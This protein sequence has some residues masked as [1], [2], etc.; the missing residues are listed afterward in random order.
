MARGMCQT[1]A[2]RAAG[3]AESGSLS[4]VVRDPAFQARVAELS[5]EL[6]WTEGRDPS[7]LLAALR[8]AYD[9]AM[10]AKK[11]DSVARIVDVAG[12]LRRDRGAAGGA[13]GGPDLDA[14]AKVYGPPRP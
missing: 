1:V 6:P 9:G 5:R 3:Y 7:P 14:W 8:L 11:F 4:R 10:A 12:R 13:A 2:A